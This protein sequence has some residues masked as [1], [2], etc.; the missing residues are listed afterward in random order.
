[1]VVGDLWYFGT[2]GTPTGAIKKNQGC[3]VRFLASVGVS[4]AG[5]CE[6]CAK[7]GSGGGELMALDVYWPRDIER[8]LL[9]LASAGAGRGPE[10]HAALAD[11]ALAFGVAS[12]GG[13]APNWPRGSVSDVL[14]VRS[15]YRVVSDD[16]DTEPG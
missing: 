13:H 10:Y 5:A 12:P 11:L 16:T 9:A 6:T 15:V 3:G 8:V 2:L 4:G 1:M 14:A 7:W